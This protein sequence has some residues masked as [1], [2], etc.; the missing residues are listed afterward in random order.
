MNF[1]RFYK[2]NKGEDAMEITTKYGV[3]DTVYFLQSDRI[4]SGKIS[5]ID[6]LANTKGTETTYTVV[7]SNIDGGQRVVRLSKE[8]DLYNDLEDIFEFLRVEYTKYKAL[9][10][11]VAEGLKN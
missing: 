10:R 6:V 7:S 9:Q 1:V 2:L 4:C 5:A 3:D 8:I 11:L